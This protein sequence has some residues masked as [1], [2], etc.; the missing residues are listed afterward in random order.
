MGKCTDQWCCWGQTRRSD[1]VFLSVNVY[2]GS[3][4]SHTDLHIMSVCLGIRGRECWDQSTHYT[5][6]RPLLPCL[7][8]ASN[9]SPFS[10]RSRFGTLVNKTWTYYLQNCFI[11]LLLFSWFNYVDLA[12]LSFDRFLF[13]VRSK[14]RR[15]QFFLPTEI[16]SGG[17]AFNV[18]ELGLMPCQARVQ[19]LVVWHL[20]WTRLADFQAIFLWWQY[21]ILYCQDVSAMS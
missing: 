5:D 6:V 1:T 19:I 20:K 4:L 12:S 11:F 8:T 10:T 7:V 2:L 13:N 21:M 18:W 9:S 17:W 3:W 14:I 16:S 15:L